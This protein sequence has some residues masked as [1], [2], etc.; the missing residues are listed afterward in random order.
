MHI[1]IVLIVAFCFFCSPAIANDHLEATI[2]N[3]ELKE[4]TKIGMGLLLEDGQEALLERIPDN[5]DIMRGGES[6]DDQKVDQLSIRESFRLYE[7]KKYKEAFKSLLEI[8]RTGNPEAQETIGLMLING[9]GVKADDKQAIRWMERAAKKI[10]PVAMHYLGVMHFKGSGVQRDIVEG[11][12]WL[13]LASEV[14]DDDSDEQKRAEEDL[15]NVI[16]RLSLR[17][18]HSAQNRVEEWKVKNSAAFKVQ[19]RIKEALKLKKEK[20][21]RIRSE[22]K[23]KQK[24]EQ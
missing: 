21:K 20:D 4:F 9:Q 15:H 16:L 19:Q 3:E 23:K 13:Q 11:A 1:F 6:S 18:Q 22:R 10:R 14:Y 12:M 24:E 7:A 17:E 8:A 2:E 5:S